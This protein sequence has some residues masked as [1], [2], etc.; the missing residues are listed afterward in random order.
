M[1]W[2]GI[3]HC[4][5]HQKINSIENST[6]TNLKEFILRLK[7]VGLDMLKQRGSWQATGTKPLGSEFDSMFG[8]EIEDMS[9]VL[10]KNSAMSSSKARQFLSQTFQV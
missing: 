3:S 6:P 9:E 1:K 2:C 4:F 8:H 5:L 7:S 10:V